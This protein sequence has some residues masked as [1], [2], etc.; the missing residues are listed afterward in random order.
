MSA[1]YPQGPSRESDRHFVRGTDWPGSKRMGSYKR[2]EADCIDEQIVEG[3]EP[4]HST[5]APPFPLRHFAD[6]EQSVRCSC[7]VRAAYVRFSAIEIGAIPLT[8]GHSQP[9]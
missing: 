1:A 7:R 2:D 8:Y 5:H 6:V 3:C 9:V 4:L